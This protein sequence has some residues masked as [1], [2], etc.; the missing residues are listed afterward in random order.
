MELRQ[1]TSDLFGRASLEVDSLFE[2]KDCVAE[3]DSL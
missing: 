2:G 1:N 3:S